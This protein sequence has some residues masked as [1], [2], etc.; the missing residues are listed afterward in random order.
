[1]GSIRMVNP[2]ASGGTR[3]R[4]A[5]P[6]RKK[7]TSRQRASQTQKREITRLSCS[8]EIRTVCRWCAGRWV[9]SRVVV[10]VNG[11]RL[12]FRLSVDAVVRRKK[13]RR[14]IIRQIVQKCACACE[15]R[16]SAD[17]VDSANR[18]GNRLPLGGYIN[19]ALPASFPRKLSGSEFSSKTWRC[20]QGRES[21]STRSAIQM[22]SMAH[23]KDVVRREMAR[24]GR[25]P[26]A[27]TPL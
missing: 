17:E 7:K 11:G 22:N 15:E 26:C 12:S 1:M 24:S 20:R 19:L 14:L 8:Q 18:L 16:T 6:A 3:E 27:A 25:R 4:R 2:S 21:S 23:T 9:V 13:I 10:P 5:I